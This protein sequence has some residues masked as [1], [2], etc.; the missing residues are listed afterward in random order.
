MK[1]VANQLNQ[2]NKVCNECGEIL[3]THFS[4]VELD[5]CHAAIPYI[6][7]SKCQKNTLDTYGFNNLMQA[8]AIL[9]DE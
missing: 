3:H 1:V 7:C 5:F 8:L 6:V 4:F 2:L 9:I